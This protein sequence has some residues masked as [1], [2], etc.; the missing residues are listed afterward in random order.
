VKTQILL[1]GLKLFKTVLGLGSVGVDTR[2]IDME[3]VAN[4]DDN[5]GEVDLSQ[6]EAGGGVCEGKMV[7][8]EREIGY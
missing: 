1:D 7:T 6:A 8:R 4:Q 2:D 5:L 3:P